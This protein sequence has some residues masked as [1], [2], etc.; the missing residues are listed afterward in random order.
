TWMADPTAEDELFERYAGE[1]ACVI[2][3]ACFGNELDL[4]RYAGL[5]DRHGVGVV[6]DAAASLGSCD[7]SGAGSG[8]GFAWPVVVSMHAT[9]TFATSEGGLI[10]AADVE[11]I[12]RLG[13]MGNF[14]FGQPRVAT[15]P[16]LNS[17]LSEVG[18]L[19]GIHKLDELEPIVEHRV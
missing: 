16:G 6:I 17:K 18:A 8:T 13:A 1:I 3:Y 10:Y 11:R 15:M 7:A 2:P 14:G 4:E 5:A 12:E 9:K 19:L